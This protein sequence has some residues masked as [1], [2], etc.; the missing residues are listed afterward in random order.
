MNALS[1]ILIQL[2]ALTGLNLQNRSLSAIFRELLASNSPE[3]SFFLAQVLKIAGN[4]P[5]LS[6]T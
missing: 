1:E 5:E 4:Q 3:A 2:H 6:P